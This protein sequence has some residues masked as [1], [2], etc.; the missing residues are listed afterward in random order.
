MAQFDKRW[1]RACPATSH[2]KHVRDPSQAQQGRQTGR[3]IGSGYL[4]LDPQC[5]SWSSSS[6]W[7]A[8]RTARR[9]ASPWPAQ[10]R[11]R[12]TYPGGW[13]SHLEL[14]WALPAE[15]D[16]YEGLADGRT[17]VPYDRPGFGLSGTTS[18]ADVVEPEL[19]VLHRHA[20]TLDATDPASAL[21]VDLR[22]L[23]LRTRSGVRDPVRRP[24]SRRRLPLPD[25]LAD[26]P[27]QHPDR[28]HGHRLGPRAV[29]LR[30]AR[31]S[32]PARSL[33]RPARPEL[34]PYR[35]SGSGGRAT[36]SHR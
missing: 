24:F 8:L 16:F 9:S 20:H 32:G 4:K 7:P 12:C 15:R 34:P 11:W 21:G 5:R 29:S 17:L 31:S 36:P 28:R 25:P 14:G 13:I 2:W 18:R 19:E 6:V 27:V 3:E 30:S 26:P 35:R 33:P 10:V 22:R 23:F 1:L